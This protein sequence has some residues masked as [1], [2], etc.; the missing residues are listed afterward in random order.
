MPFLL[1]S[2]P[3]ATDIPRDNFA[4]FIILHFLL[5]LLH[6]PAAEQQADRIAAVQ[7]A[8]SQWYSIRHS[9]TLDDAT[10]NFTCVA[11]PLYWLAMAIQGQRRSGALPARGEQNFAVVRRWL[12]DFWPALR[13][14]KGDVTITPDSNS[15]TGSKPP[16]DQGIVD[17]VP[18]PI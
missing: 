3:L 4:S 11:L 6:H 13:V 14:D 7:T 16:P 1:G 10:I 17:W 9:F 5:R 15:M 8:F 12:W 2:A 18:V